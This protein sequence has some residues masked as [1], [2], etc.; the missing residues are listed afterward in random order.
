MSKKAFKLLLN[1]LR[2][3]RDNEIEVDG[4]LDLVIDILE[5]QE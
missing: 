3:F 4:E 2:A 5:E 1:V